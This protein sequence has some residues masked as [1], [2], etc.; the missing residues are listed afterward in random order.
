MVLG[1]A[2]RFSSSLAPDQLLSLSEAHLENKMVFNVHGRERSELLSTHP[3]P[4]TIYTLFLTSHHNQGT[5][6]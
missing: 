5:Y 4:D 1:L 3:V 2:L 6:A